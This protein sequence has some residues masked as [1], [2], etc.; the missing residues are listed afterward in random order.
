MTKQR[1]KQLLK[2]RAARVRAVRKFQ[3]QVNLGLPVA[4]AKQP[5]ILESIGGNIGDIFG[6]E[7]LGSSIGRGVS[8]FFRAISGSGDYKITSNSLMSDQVPTFVGGRKANPIRCRE[9]VKDI[10][11]SATAGA[12]NV[13]TFNVNPGNPALFPWLSGQA[14]GWSEYKFHGLIFEFKTASGQMVSS[15]NTTLGTVIMASQYNLND[16]A[17]VNKQQ[18]ENSEF[19]TPCRP[20]DSAIHPIE[21]AAVDT[22]I[23]VLNIQKPGQST[24]NNDPRFNHL[25]KFSIATIGMQ[26]TSTNVGE[27]WASYE[28][29]FLKILNL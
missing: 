17:F 14:Q 7:K 26:G 21:C 15:T 9:F 3:Q 29:E 20:S 28:V 12:F 18:I 22:S 19:S 23:T 27:L 24:T 2:K 6:R 1:P 11:T 4:I 5:G 25:C 16:P 13:E 8:K 10:I